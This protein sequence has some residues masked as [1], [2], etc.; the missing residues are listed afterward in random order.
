MKPELSEFFSSMDAYFRD[1]RQL[2]ALRARFPGWDASPSRLAVYGRFVDGH[3]Q[4]TLEKLFPLTR[5]VMSAEQWA[6]IVRAYY[7]TAPAQ[8]FE[9]NQ[10]GASFGSF[11]ADRTE[12]E[13]VAAFV[14]AVAKFEW[15]DFE[16]YASEEEI[17]SQV[18]ALTANP[19][20]TV[21]QHPFRLVPWMRSN[22]RPA[23]PEQGDETVL[24]W[25]HPKTHL[26]T[27]LAADPRSLL[28]LKL[29]VEG[30]SIE[31]AAAA[32]GISP[33]EVR[34]FVE[35]FARDGMVLSAFN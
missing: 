34:A 26:T 12:A 20:L 23:A 2:Q 4:G 14:P 19:T 7:E 15:A 5:S 16:V 25:R 21:L 9:I 24:M 17:P 27:Y 8:H 32:G 35:L 10:L 1:S 18:R 11:L 33:A 6:R 3:V 31:D 28:V 30:I 13:G 22:P 29:A